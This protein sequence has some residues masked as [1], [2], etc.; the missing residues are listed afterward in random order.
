MAYIKKNVE[1]H[2][3]KIITILTMFAHNVT[4]LARLVPLEPNMIVEIVMKPCIGKMENVKTL[5]ILITTRMKMITY[6]IHATKL[7]KNVSLVMVNLAKN[8]MM[9]LT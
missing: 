1:T 4:Y 6:V 5:V 8:V 9:V 7:V 2:A 3:Q